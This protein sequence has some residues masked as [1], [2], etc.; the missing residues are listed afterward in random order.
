MQQVMIFEGHEVEVFEWNGQVLFNP[1]HVGTCL[2]IENV[3]VRRHI[4]NMNEK[5]VI[6]L[7]NLDVQDMNIR[8][9]NNAGENFLTESGVYKLIFKSRKEEA[10]R[11][12]DWVTD[13][14][15]PSI[16]QTGS[17]TKEV[18]QCNI[19]E[20]VKETIC[21]VVPEIIRELED[22]EERNKRAE[23]EMKKLET[24]TKKKIER[25]LYSERYSYYEISKLL[26]QEGIDTSTEAICFYAQNIGL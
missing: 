20:I 13:E 19:K 17:Y 18:N 5:Q 10:E 2:D 21:Q 7:K 22:K 14:V 6:L 1:Y 25:L 9:L 12:Q 15:L 23:R 11:F 24:A 16:R 26:K 4:Q 8:K 3:T